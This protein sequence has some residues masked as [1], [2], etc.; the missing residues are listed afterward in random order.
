LGTIEVNPLAVPPVTVK[1][2]ALLFPAGVVTVTFLAPTPAFAEMVTVAVTCVSEFTVNEVTVMPLGAPPPTPEK[3]TAVVP[4]RP[5]PVNTTVTPVV[6]VL[7]E[8]GAIAVSTGP[9]IANGSV[10]LAPPAVVTSIFTLPIGVE[11]VLLNVASMVVEFTN[12]TPL[13]V[14]PATAGVATTFAPATKLVPVRTTAWEVPRNSELGEMDVRVVAD[15]LTT[16]NV[17]GPTDVPPKVTLTFLA[18]T[19]AFAAMV[20]VAVTVV[21]LTAAKLLTVMP[22]P[23]PPTPVTVTAVAPVRPVPV[24]VTFTAAPWA[25]VLGAIEFRPP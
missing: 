10:L 1:V 24:I 17:T 11:V 22:L 2:R 16:E 5:D 18:P 25:P 8:V 3:L 15:A 20:K 12:V 19:V 21:A 4:V 14:K 13:M 7:P 23:P 6:P 9:V